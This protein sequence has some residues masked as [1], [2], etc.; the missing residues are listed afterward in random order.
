ME[1]CA[2]GVAQYDLGGPDSP[3]HVDPSHCFDFDFNIHHFYWQKAT[4]VPMQEVAFW[5]E[6]TG[7]LEN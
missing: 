2:P 5:F 6:N 7:Y 1:S 4:E 3:E